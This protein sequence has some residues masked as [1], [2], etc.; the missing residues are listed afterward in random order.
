MTSRVDP[1]SM[2]RTWNG[3]ARCP[4]YDCVLERRG[5]LAR[6]LARQNQIALGHPECPESL[7]VQ[8]FWLLGTSPEPSVRVDVARDPLC[9]NEVLDLPSYDPWWEVRSAV[10]A[11]PSHTLDSAYRLALDVN[12][13]VRR[14][15]AEG[16]SPWVDVLAVLAVDRDSGVRDAVAEHPNCPPGVLAML[17][18][19]PVWEIRRSV[20]KRKDAPPPVLAELASDPEHWVRF[21][22]GI[23]P[24]TPQAIRH[25]LEGDPRLIVRTTAKRRR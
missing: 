9:P 11:N 24:A 10:A 6:S 21:F 1:A 2:S 12:S 22:A 17:S 23:N 16:S 8:L 19:D 20:A 7:R 15:L 3:D 18:Q 14:A 13:W 25:E 5:R 4:L